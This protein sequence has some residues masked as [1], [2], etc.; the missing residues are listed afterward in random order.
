MISVIYP[1]GAEAPD[2]IALLSRSGGIVVLLLWVS[3]PP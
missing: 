3:S 2:D 1:P